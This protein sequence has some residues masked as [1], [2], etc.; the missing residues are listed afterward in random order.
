MPEE[1]GQ[2]IWTQWSDLGYPDA[3]QPLVGEVIQWEDWNEHYSVPREA[4][5]EGIIA[6]ARQLWERSGWPCIP[7]M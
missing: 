4:I 5:R 1:G 2:R 3:L 7:D 6:A